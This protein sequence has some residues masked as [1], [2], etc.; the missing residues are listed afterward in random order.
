MKARPLCLTSL[1]LLSLALL[2]APPA[3][4]QYQWRDD[5]GRMVFSD[6]PPPT[7]VPLNRVLRAPQQAAAAA[8]ADPAAAAAS[9]P[10]GSASDRPS[11]AKAAPSAPETLADK[12]MAFRKRMA[13]RAELQKKDREEREKA[14]ELARDCENSRGELH[15]LE[16][17]APIRRTTAAGERVYVGEQE[18]QQRLA[19]VRKSLAEHCR[20]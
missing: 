16:S 11:H 12:E 17:G 20:I 10:S 9:A 5:S 3:A 2:S 14:K 18:R 13:E 4:G 1:G 19:A 7:S 6:Q 15:A 8:P